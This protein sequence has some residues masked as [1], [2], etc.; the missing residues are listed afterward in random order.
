MEMRIRCSNTC[1]H[2]K[3]ISIIFFFLLF[4]SP[5]PIAKAIANFRFSIFDFQALWKTFH[6]GKQII[7]GWKDVFIFFFSLLNTIIFEST[8]IYQID[9]Q[10]KFIINKIRSTCSMS[11]NPILTL[12]WN[13]DLDIG[14]RLFGWSKPSDHSI[15]FF[16]GNIYLT[17]FFQIIHYFWFLACFMY[18]KS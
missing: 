2:F 17:C 6:Q 1:V 10:W 14:F 7:I 12:D 8:W 9:N 15:V 5:N 4:S 3:E 13:I 11:Q 18:H 16:Y